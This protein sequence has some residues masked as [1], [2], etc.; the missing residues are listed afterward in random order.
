VLIG[1]ASQHLSADKRGKA[2]GIVNAGGSLG[3]FVLA[4][5]TQTLIQR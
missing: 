3:Q 5:V 2:A 4:P 1:A